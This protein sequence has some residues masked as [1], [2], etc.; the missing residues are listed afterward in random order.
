[1]RFLLALLFCKLSGGTAGLILA[2]LFL[3]VFVLVAIYHGRL[4]DGITRNGLMLNIKLVRCSHQSDW[5]R[6]PR[7]HQTRRNPGILLKQ[8]ST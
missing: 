3:L 8:I 2:A 7:S 1:M 6:L 4:L 5:E